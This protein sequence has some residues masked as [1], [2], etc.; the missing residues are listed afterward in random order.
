MSLTE[1]GL[2]AALATVIDPHTGKDFVSTRAV[3]N[4]QISGSDVAFDVELG[5]PAKSLVA[6]YRKQLIA[7]AKTLPGVENVSANVYTKVQAH[8]VQRGVQLVPGVKNIIAVA[9]GKA[10]S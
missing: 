9:S 8:A 6:D 2:L 7:A 10:M 3:R 5:Y 4:V 1:Q